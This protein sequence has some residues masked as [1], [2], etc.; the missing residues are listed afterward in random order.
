MGEVSSLGPSLRTGRISST[1]I[2][3]CL[4][5]VADCT[6]WDPKGLNPNVDRHCMQ[7]RGRPSDPQIH[8]LRDMFIQRNWKQFR[9]YS[10]RHSTEKRAPRHRVDS[11]MWKER[12]SSCHCP[13]VLISP[14]GCP[15][16]LGHRWI[17]RQSDVERKRVMC[18]SWSPWL[19]LPFRITIAAPLHHGRGPFLEEQQKLFGDLWST[20]LNFWRMKSVRT[21]SKQTPKPVIACPAL[22]E[23]MCKTCFSKCQSLICDMWIELEIATN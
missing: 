1:Q 5:R 12:S 7:S 16:P 3:P 19:V 21:V 4:M 10:R 14:T 6:I 8:Y 17:C 2:L 15:M 13:C 11:S 22:T 18:F 23:V 20:D 9:V